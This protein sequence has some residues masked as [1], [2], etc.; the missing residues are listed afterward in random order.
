MDS[1]PRQYSIESSSRVR[2]AYLRSRFPEL[3]RAAADLRDAP[4]VIDCARRF[5]GS[6]RADRALDLLEIAIDD[7]SEDE[8]LWL[9]RLEILAFAGR[10]NQFLG[11]VRDFLDVHPD[12]AN[13]G[14]IVHFWKRFAPD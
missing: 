9:A 5:L 10:R 12:S 2:D 7:R 8:A 13:I 1:A 11:V 3:I 6:G 14:E 4:V